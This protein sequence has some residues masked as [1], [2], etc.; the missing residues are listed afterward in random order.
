MT[1]KEHITKEGL[2][3]IVSIKSSINRGLSS[4]LYAA[5]PNILPIPRPLVVDSAL[6]VLEGSSRAKVAGPEEIIP[7]YGEQWLSGFTSVRSR[8]MFQSYS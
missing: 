3:K 7:P 2:L 6:P 4:E 1:G 8:R 5:F